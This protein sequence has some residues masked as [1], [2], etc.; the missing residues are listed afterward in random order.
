MLKGDPHTALNDPYSVVITEE[1]AHKYFGDQNPIG[2]NINYDGRFDFQVTGVI[3]NIPNNSHLKFDFVFSL[4]C[5]PTVFSKDFLENR[6]N[7]SV[8]NYFQLRPA[9]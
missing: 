1:T 3:A 8:Y 4:A 9:A 7:T 5:A 6:M 2:K